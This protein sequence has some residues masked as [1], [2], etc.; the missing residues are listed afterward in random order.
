[1]TKNQTRGKCKGILNSLYEIHLNTNE[2]F[3]E[4]HKN[5]QNRKLNLGEIEKK[6]KYP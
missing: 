1:L 4:F 3:Q 5:L 6:E 2:N